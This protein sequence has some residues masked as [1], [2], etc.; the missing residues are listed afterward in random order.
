MKTFEMT[1]FLRI[2]NRMVTWLFR[3][4]SADRADGSAHRAR[5]ARPTP[6]ITPV[7]LTRAGDEW[8]LVAAYGRVEWVK[9]LQKPREA[10]NT[11]K[12]R[13]IEVNANHA[14]FRLTSR[15]GDLP[16]Q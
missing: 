5:P 12:R 14:V 15:S 6:R 10:T 8:L 3:F 1:R 7:A 9:N 4:F 13:R 16:Q 2:G 11:R